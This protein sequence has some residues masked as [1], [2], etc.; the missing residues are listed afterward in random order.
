MSEISRLLKQPV[1]SSAVKNRQWIS[2]ALAEHEQSLVRYA[3]F[4]VRNVESAKDIVQ[5]TF[6]K[7]CQQ[8][9]QLKAGHLKAWLFRVCRNGAIDFCR[10]EKRVT[11]S[12]IAVSELIGQ[13]EPEPSSVMEQR[14]THDSVLK[15]VSN[16]PT[17]QQEVLRLK[18]QSGLSYQEIADVTG[19]SQSN[20]GVLLHTAIGMLRT[21]LAP[22]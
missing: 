9:Q 19:L 21:R 6:L 20:V 15:Q 11:S 22:E 18:F 7:L 8:E 12:D 3:H 4:F 16:L 1:I 10:K 17:N 5:D 13:K 14:D 2:C